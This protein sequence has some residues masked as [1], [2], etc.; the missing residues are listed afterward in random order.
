MNDSEFRVSVIAE[1]IEANDVQDS[2]E[3]DLAEESQKKIVIG[4]IEVMGNC[5]EN[6]GESL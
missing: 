1:P 2:G 3:I 5:E 6:E 4:D